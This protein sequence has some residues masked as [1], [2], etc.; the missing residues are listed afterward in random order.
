MS[1]LSFACKQ[2]RPRVI[3]IGG[4]VSPMGAQLIN[5]DVMNVDISS[6]MLE[7]A[8]LQYGKRGAERLCFVCADAAE[9][10]I[11]DQSIDIIMMFA[12]LHHMPDP[13][14]FLASLKPLLRAD[15]IIAFLCE[16]LSDSMDDPNIIADLVEGINEQVFCL[17]EYVLICQ[18]AGLYEG[19]FMIN[20]GSINAVLSAHFQSAASP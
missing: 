10:P 3:E 18:R 7:L 1:A 15:G 8:A 19:E 14:G 5:C 13:A 16:P 9:L 17:E 4:G 11:A 2:D 20:G 12:T 6:P